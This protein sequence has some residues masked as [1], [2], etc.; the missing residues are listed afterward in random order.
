MSFTT[1]R[2]IGIAVSELVRVMLQTVWFIRFEAEHEDA[3]HRVESLPQC[4][5]QETQP[6]AQISSAASC[7]PP[8]Y[9]LSPDGHGPPQSVLPKDIQLHQLGMHQVLTLPLRQ[10]QELHFPMSKLGD[11]LW[12]HCVV[13]RELSHFRVSGN[14]RSC[15]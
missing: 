7:F 5:V 10:A 13:A 12:A 4:W 1:E 15:K 2:Y 6:F 3:P 9:P 8:S 11:P 14:L